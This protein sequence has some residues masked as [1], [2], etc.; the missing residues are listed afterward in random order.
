MTFK[1]IIPRNIDKWNK[2]HDIIY[3]KT[4]KDSIAVVTAVI[5]F[6]NQV[7]KIC[8]VVSL[9]VKNG[10]QEMDLILIDDNSSDEGSL[11]LI[12]FFEN[13]LVDSKSLCSVMIIQNEIQL[14]ETYCDDLGIRK[15]KT[16]YVIEIQ[17]DMFMNHLGFDTKLIKAL[18]SKDDFIAVSGRG[19][20]DFN[21]VFEKYAYSSGSI[22]SESSNPNAFLKFIIKEL[23]SNFRTMILELLG[24]FKEDS[25]FI[26][27]KNLRIDDIAMFPDMKLFEITKSAGRLGS[28]I[29]QSLD[30]NAKFLN[31]IWVSDTIM[32]GPIIFDK[33]K[34]LSVGGFNADSFFLGFDD[35]Y[36]FLKSFNQMGYRCGFTP[37][38]Y[39]T[40]PE[41]G[42][43]RKKRNL[44]TLLIIY[45]HLMRISKNKLNVEIPLVEPNPRID[46]FIL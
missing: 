7:N 46:H 37:I 13:N 26:E 41:C 9:L 10:E 21:V 28:S 35:H 11:E 18:A 40:Y 33:S 2:Y 38:D 31:K 16:N 45:Q 6:Y 19:C 32:R 25:K 20:H 36:L 42:S 44:R 8:E 43:T 14:F 22:I 17:S 34:Y 15:A 29:F 4:F 3:K 5:P 39:F 30:E 27:T 12:K 24:I 1:I 23:L